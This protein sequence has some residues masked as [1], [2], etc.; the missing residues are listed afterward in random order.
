AVHPAVLHHLP[1][2]RIPQR[3]GRLA[4]LEALGGDEPRT[5]IARVLAQ[6]AAR[7]WLAAVEAI[8]GRVVAHVIHR[9]LAANDELLEKRGARLARHVGLE[10]RQRRLEW[11]DVP[12]VEVRRKM[13]GAV[14]LRLGPRVA[15]RRQTDLDEAREPPLPLAGAAA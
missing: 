14:E 7:P 10:R 15:V 6:G 11:A 8:V 1:L 4:G 12:E 9:E 13:A 5:W 2:R 3:V